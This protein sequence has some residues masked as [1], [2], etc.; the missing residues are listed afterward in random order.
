MSTRGF[1]GIVRENGTVDYKYRHYDNYLEGMGIILS[2][3]KTVEEVK[4]FL[5][6]DENEKHEPWEECESKEKFL[7]MAYEIPEGKEY[8]IGEE[9]HY[10]FDM[11]DGEWYV[12]S[13]HGKNKSYKLNDLLDDEKELAPFKEMY[14]DAYKNEFVERCKNRKSVL[15]DSQ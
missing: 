6:N 2:R 8:P 12:A 5:N 11:S 4:D 13:H 15:D 3:M 9:F 1:I 14:V 7:S 10:V